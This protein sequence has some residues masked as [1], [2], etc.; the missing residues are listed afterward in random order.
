MKAEDLQRKK[1]MTRQKRIAQSIAEYF[2]K[3]GKIMTMKEYIAENDT[4]HRA[5]AVRKITGS[6]GRLI[7]LIKVN[8]PKEYEQAT[9]P[10][11]APKPAAKAKATVAKKG[12]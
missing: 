3:K 10:A 9:K 11:P 4:P 6:W 7:Q 1:K 5:R 8:F 12:K 2:A